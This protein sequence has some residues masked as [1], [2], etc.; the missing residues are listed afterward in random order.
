MYLPSNMKSFL[1]ILFSFCYCNV[2]LAQRPYIAFSTSGGSISDSSG[3]T[4]LYI[5][6]PIIGIKLK[7]Q[8]ITGF[9][10][11]ILNVRTNLAPGVNFPT[12]F[13]Y[14]IFNRY[15]FKKHDTSSYNQKFFNPFIDA[16]VRYAPN[17]F[18][19]LAWIDTLDK[20]REIIPVVSVGS[21]LAIYKKFKFSLQFGFAYFKLLRFQQNF[22]LEYHF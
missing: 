15:Y 1:I 4:T 8:N 2:V 10:L 6:E 11:A 17:S 21:T 13:N 7:Q 12:R 19:D 16:E 9:K 18:A 5:L 22:S 14:T 20:Q 3:R